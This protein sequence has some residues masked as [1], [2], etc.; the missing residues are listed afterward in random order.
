MASKNKETLMG[1]RKSAAPRL[2]SNTSQ[3]NATVYSTAEKPHYRKY[4]FVDFNFGLDFIDPLALTNIC[5]TLRWIYTV[6]V[7]C[8]FLPDF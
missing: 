7:F 3:R 6:S 1:V 8:P 4:D 2:N 5:N